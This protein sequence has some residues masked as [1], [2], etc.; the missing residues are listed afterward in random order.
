MPAYSARQRASRGRGSQMT[1]AWWLLVAFIGGG[2][3]GMLIMTLV[4]MA[5]DLPEQ[6]DTCPRGSIRND[7]IRLPGRK[8]TFCSFRCR[9]AFA[10]ANNLSQRDS[11]DQQFVSQYFERSG[12]QMR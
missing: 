7:P 1:S 4:R 10:D 9:D 6:F 8:E 12:R 11:E 3:S 2:W 5:G